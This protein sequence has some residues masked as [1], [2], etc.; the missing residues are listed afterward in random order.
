MDGSHQMSVMNIFHLFWWFTNRVYKWKIV[1]FI[2]K[3][4]RGSWVWCR[5]K[6]CSHL[7]FSFKPWPVWTY[8]EGSFCDASVFIQI[9]RGCGQGCNLPDGPGKDDT[10]SMFSKTSKESWI[11]MLYLI[12]F[13]M[14]KYALRHGTLNGGKRI[15]DNIAAGL[16]PHFDAEILE[17]Q[18]LQSTE[19]TLSS[20]GTSTPIEI[21][22]LN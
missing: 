22:F 1:E 11:E 14:K 13:V 16:A 18:T 7:R 19:F 17:L 10:E 2:L 12:Y 21:I 15:C 6:F 9:N 3:K 5:V 20:P 4:A 8:Q